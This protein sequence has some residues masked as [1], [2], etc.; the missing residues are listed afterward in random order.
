MGNKYVNATLESLQSKESRV[1]SSELFGLVITLIV[2][3]VGVVGCVG[4]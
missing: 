1:D 2:H 3:S 4:C